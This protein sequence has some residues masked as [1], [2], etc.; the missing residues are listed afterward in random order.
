MKSLFKAT[1][2]T[3]LLASAFAAHAGTSASAPTSTA[4]TAVPVQLSGLM[5]TTVQE[6]MADAIIPA[7]SVADVAFVSGFD[8]QMLGGEVSGMPVLLH[9]TNLVEFIPSGTK[10]RPTKC[11]ILADGYRSK[12]WARTYF[13]ADR[14]S[15]FYNNGTYVEG[16]VEGYLIGVDNKLGVPDAQTAPGQKARIIVTRDVFLDR[17]D[18]GSN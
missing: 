4:P 3:V 1:A 5:T 6:R 15:C 12:G 7:T 18:V 2:L 17:K 14:M 13:R 9:V 11:D 16:P 10:A 8:A